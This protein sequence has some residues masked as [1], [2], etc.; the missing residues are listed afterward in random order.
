MC[1]IKCCWLFCFVHG[2]FSCVAVLAC[3]GCWNFAV[4]KK[5]FHQSP[6]ST[7]C[8]HVLC[9]CVCCLNHRGVLSFVMTNPRRTDFISTIKATDYVLANKLTWPLSRMINSDQ[10]C[11]YSRIYWRIMLHCQADVLYWNHRNKPNKSWCQDLPVAIF[12][13]R[14]H[15]SYTNIQIFSASKTTSDAFL[16]NATLLSLPG[17]PLCCLYLLLLMSPMD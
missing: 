2:F 1:F 13:P 9:R 15:I 16:P 10:C 17:I 8:A 5:Q 7:D 12:L 3:Q 14:A 6:F 4:K 11:V